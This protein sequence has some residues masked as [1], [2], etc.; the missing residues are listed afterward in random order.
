MECMFLCHCECACVCACVCAEEKG[1]NKPVH[2]LGRSYK[3]ENKKNQKKKHYKSFL[4][5]TLCSVLS[6]S[7]S[8]A[9]DS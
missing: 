7:R 6:P 9:L 8:Q 3:T 1:G 2:S 4:A 5:C